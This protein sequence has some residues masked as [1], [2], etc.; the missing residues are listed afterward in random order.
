MPEAHREVRVVYLSLF[1]PAV[2]AGASGGVCALPEAGALRT[3]LC[4]I[5]VK[6]VRKSVAGFR[7]DKWQLFNA[8]I[9]GSR[10]AA[11]FVL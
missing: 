7:R 2:L 8:D 4:Q 5:N 3:M 9:V 11:A 6:V 10:H 1:M